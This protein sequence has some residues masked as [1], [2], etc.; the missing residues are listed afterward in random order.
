MGRRP[1]IILAGLALLALFLV[2]L[3]RGLGLL[4]GVELKAYDAY[5]RLAGDRETPSQP[6]VMVEFSDEDEA[7]FGYP[8]PDD[9]L[10]DL[11]EVLTTKGAVA[12]GLDL[13]RDRPEPKTTDRSSFE[14]LSRILRNNP[15][16]VG[17]LKDGDGT[18]G[19]PPALVDRPLQ[20]ASAAILPDGATR[21]AA[22]R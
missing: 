20:V 15:S 1:F 16:I 19:P 11:F 21:S 8:L 22:A 12:I 6:V 9:R 10:S 18:F 17:I 4:E 14:R 13:I 5:L 7:A 2:L 3:L